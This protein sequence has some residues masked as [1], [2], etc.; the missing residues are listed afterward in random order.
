MRIIPVTDRSP[1]RPGKCHDFN[2]YDADALSRACARWPQGLGNW[3]NNALLRGQRGIRMKAFVLAVAV[4]AAFATS[5]S[6]QVSTGREEKSPH[7]N[8]PEPP[9]PDDKAYKAALQRIPDPKQKYDPWGGVAPAAPSP[10]PAAAAKK[11]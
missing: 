5:A 2:G 9:K 7:A 1:R 11:K 3:R 10:A 4:L 6:A 8:P